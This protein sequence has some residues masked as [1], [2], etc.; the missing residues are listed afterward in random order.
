MR[1]SEQK[2]QEN[3]NKI[4][5]INPVTVKTFLDEALSGG[6]ADNWQKLEPKTTDLKLVEMPLG[7]DK[8][9]SKRNEPKNEL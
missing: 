1:M 6:G 4:S 9:N 2:M 8:S 5:L 3:Q 7:G